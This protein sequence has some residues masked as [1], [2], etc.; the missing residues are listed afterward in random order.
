MLRRSGIKIPDSGFSVLE[1]DDL[2]ETRSKYT[3]FLEN[4]GP[5]SVTQLLLHPRVL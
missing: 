3:T 5:N 2:R 4:V 1:S